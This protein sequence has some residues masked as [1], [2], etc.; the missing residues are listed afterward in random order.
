MKSYKTIKNISSTLY[1]GLKD[2]TDVR[3]RLEDAVQQIHSNLSQ[4]FKGL[5]GYELSLSGY[6]IYVDEETYRQS[7]TGLILDETLLNN[8]EF[9]LRVE[10]LIDHE[11]IWLK[12]TAGKEIPDF[13]QIVKRIESVQNSEG[14][15]EL[16]EIK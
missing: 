16:K 8:E 10:Y 6:H 9:R 14:L 12:V 13:S 11:K 5:F 15:T 7:A 4:D 2:E 1:L 3:Y